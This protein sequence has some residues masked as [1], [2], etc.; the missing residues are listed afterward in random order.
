VFAKADPSAYTEESIAASKASSGLQNGDGHP[1]NGQGQGNGHAD[2]TDGHSNGQT[3]STNG[4][5]NGHD[6]SQDY[7]GKNTGR[8]ARC[9]HQPSWLQLSMHCHQNTPHHCVNSICHGLFMA[10]YKVVLKAHLRLHCHVSA[11][12][13]LNGRSS[14]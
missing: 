6:A 4:Q 2:H 1:A 3:A 5:S 12:M 8:K 11:T 13:A 14:T 10:F 7:N 9:H